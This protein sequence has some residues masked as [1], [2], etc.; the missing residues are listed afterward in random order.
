MHH[1]RVP[2][3]AEHRAGDEGEPALPLDGL[4]VIEIGQA[5]AAP[6]CARHL[7]DLGA[8]VIK[9]ERPGVGDLA[10]GYD[11]VV[12]G[13]SA[14]FAWANYGKKSIELDLASTEGAQLLLE[15][16]DSADVLVHN[17]GPGAMDRLGF[18]ASALA[19]RNPRLVDCAISGYG[20]DG[21]FKDEKAF[22]LLVQGEV[23]LVSATG[24]EDSPAKV[25]ISVV[26]MC[27]AV[28]ALSSIQAALL[29]RERTGIGSAVEVSLLDCIG[30][31]MM[32][33][34]Y[35]QIYGGRAPRRSGARHNM[36]V[37]YGLYRT[38]ADTAVNF[39]VQTDGQWRS[40]CD[41]VLGS[42]DLADDRRFATNPDRLEN[43]DELESMIESRLTRIGHAEAVRR[44][45][46]SQVPTG[47]VND[48][49]GFVEHEQL[50]ARKRWFD[51]EVGGQPV[52]ALRPPFHVAAEDSRRRQVPGLGEHTGEVLAELAPRTGRG[53]E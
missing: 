49:A 12:R 11:S 2:H 26:D 38:G 14:Y 3:P 18:D 39:A 19:A 43:R 47:E 44:L 45:R 48:L 53:A 40:L 16:V 17:L 52:T 5:V 46:G 1:D 50:R 32:A 4:R 34:A 37:P 9:V 29:A 41:H 30:E 27:A 15:L 21:P 22:D 23:G 6:L 36:L 24:S 10:R 31:W 28:Y 13:A 35:H 51:I 42:P 7:C 25:G 33:P 8:E 20:S